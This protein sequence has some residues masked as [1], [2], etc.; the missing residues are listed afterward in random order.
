MSIRTRLTWQFTIIVASILIFF[1]VSIYFFYADFRRDEY[2]SR[3]TNKALTNAH[4][5]IS[6]QE[7]DHDLMKIIDR[8]TLNALHNEK[9]YIFDRYN[10]LVYASVDDQA[11]EISK[12]LLDRI[13]EEE[14]IEYTQSLNETLGLA[15]TEN[16]NDFV[17]IASAFDV[18]G[19]RKMVNLRYILI[20]GSMTSLVVTFFAGRLF[21]RQALTPI[22]DFNQQVAGINEDNLHARLD[23]GNGQDEMAQLA[24]NFNQMLDRIA[25]SFALQKNFVHNASHELRTPLAAMIS[26]IQVGLSRK[27]AESEYKEL[28]QSV[29]EDAQRLAGLSNGLL[30]LAQAERDKMAIR[31]SPVRIDEILFS[32]H[33]AAL[34]PQ[35]D[36]N[37]ELEF[38]DI[39]ENENS[40]LVQGHEGMLCTVFLNLMD[41]ACKFSS[42][43]SVRVSIAFEN[44]HI[45]IAVSDEGIGIPPE[46][47]DKIFMP[48]YR[49]GNGQ[50]IRG[51]GLGLSI[52]R[53]IIL[54]HQGRIELASAP[55]QGSTFTVFLP[56]L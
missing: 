17:I 18:Y 1:F 38:S 31:T 7:I 55:G 50:Q 54:L 14:R 36:R 44:G 8:N 10:Q 33:N 49:A 42:D 37:I 34:K 30:Q 19:R 53:K 2:Y 22:A 16:G 29:L 39:P 25:S 9:I 4:L 23:E 40:L 41:N 6:V 15:Y 32:A 52:C 48:F 12:S 28:L 11:P 35:P 20:L 56:H 24:I 5:L 26:Q 21:A 51:Y 47:Q 45:S 43:H 27:R 46:E 13:R 3:L